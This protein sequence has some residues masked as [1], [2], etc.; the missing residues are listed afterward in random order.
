MVANPASLTTTAE[1][2][3]SEM[4]EC[5]EAHADAG[6]WD[7]VEDI[8]SR[9][10]NAVMHVPEADRR[11]VLLAVKRSTDKVAAGAKKARQDVTGKLSALRRGQAAKKAYELR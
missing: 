7:E 6:H 1:L 3:V 4:C 5:M 8:A 11:P 10:R 9:L 2:T